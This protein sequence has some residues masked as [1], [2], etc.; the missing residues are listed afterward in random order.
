MPLED[1]IS[2]AQQAARSRRF[3]EALAI[4][5]EA[6]RLYPDDKR[7][8]SLRGFLGVLTRD[9][10]LAIVAASRAIEIDPNDEYLLLDRGRYN[11]KAKRWQ[12]AV[13]DL[14]R[15]LELCGAHERETF[16]FLRAE[17]LLQLGRREDALADLAGVPDGENDGGFWTFRFV[18]KRDLVAECAEPLE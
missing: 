14:S 17:G 10:D 8:W 6:V 12:E 9:Y 7:A 3:P 15:G 1:L 5:T 18:R 13:N 11:L 16:L 4:T 2:S